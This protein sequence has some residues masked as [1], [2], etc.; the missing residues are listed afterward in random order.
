VRY[1][2]A[3]D[4]RFRCTLRF[5]SLRPWELGALLAALEPAR[6]EPLFGLPPH[7]P[8]YAHKLG[9]GKPLGLGSVGFTLDAVRWRE[10]DTWHWHD[11]RRAADSWQQVT[12]AALS[13]FKAKLESAYGGAAALKQHLETWCKTRRWGQ[14][15]KAIY[16][17][18][19][20][21]KI[22]TFHTDLR[23]RHAAVRRGGKRDFA[24]L[25]KLLEL[26]P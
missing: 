16:P 25:K 12:D 19:Q 18:G 4:S 2:S 5:D 6:L 15:G 21:E 13:A 8:G 22:F 23:R 3:P 20:D 26:E 14:H 10:N 11:S 24:D 1:L 17:V 7:K 9:F